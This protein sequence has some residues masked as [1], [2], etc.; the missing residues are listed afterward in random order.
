[1][2]CLFVVLAMLVLIPYVSADL[3]ITGHGSQTIHFT[4]PVPKPSSYITPVKNTTEYNNTVDNT[5]PWLN[6]HDNPN[7]TIL[8]GGQTY[9]VERDNVEANNSLVFHLTAY[10]AY[11]VHSFSFFDYDWGKE[12][13]ANADPGTVFLFVN[14]FLWKDYVNGYSPSLWRPDQNQFRLYYDGVYNKN[15][16]PLDLSYLTYTFQ[17]KTNYMHDGQPNMPY[18]YFNAPNMSEGSGV[19]NLVD[20]GWIPTGKSSGIDGYFIYEIPDRLD[21]NQTILFTASLWNFGNVAW[22]LHKDVIVGDKTLV[23]LN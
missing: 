7:T 17:N 4:I 15:I 20:Y 11:A 6:L 22:D 13:T 18:P 3:N 16:Q 8:R 21:E 5:P 10:R 23:Q 19:P 12:Y 1:M 14:V 9:T 2:K